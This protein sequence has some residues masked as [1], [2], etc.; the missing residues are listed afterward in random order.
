M[1]PHVIAGNGS[2]RMGEARRVMWSATSQEEKSQNA[3]PSPT[4]AKARFR[5]RLEPL[6]IGIGSSG[7]AVTISWELGIQLS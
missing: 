2:G 5:Q 4:T 1:L 6:R 7:D 3:T